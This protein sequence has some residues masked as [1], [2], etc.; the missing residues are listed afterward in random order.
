[1]LKQTSDEKFRE[2]LESDDIFLVNAPSVL[3]N[4]Y[5]ILIM[6]IMYSHGTVDFR[7]LRNDLDLTAGNLASHLRTLKGQKYIS[8]QKEI[9]GSRPRTSYQLTKKGVNAYAKF[10]QF[11]LMVF[12]DEQT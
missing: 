2:M 6:K 4:P 5:R 11:A 10:R 1:M 12:A 7:D 9:I 3:F 8:D